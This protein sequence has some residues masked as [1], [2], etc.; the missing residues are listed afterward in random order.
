MQHSAWAISEDLPPSAAVVALAI[1][2]LSLALLIFAEVRQAERFRAGVLAT[3]L[4]AA[5]LLLAA[6]LR[7]VRVKTAGTEVG[8]RVVVLFD[9]SRRLLL[10][11]GSS[12]RRSS[13]LEAA[14]SVQ[15][16]FAASRVSVTAFAE[17]PLAEQRPGKS[18]SG[19][20]SDLLEALNELSREGGEH[21]KAVVVIS[22]GRLSRP[23][24]IAKPS[25]MAKALSG[26]GVPIHTVRV[27]DEAPKD[28]AVRQVRAAGAAVAHQP[29]SLSIEVACSGGLTCDKL[30][31]TVR[32]L[33]Y[34][35]EPA[36]LARGTV[37][38]KD[39]VGNVDLN[40]VLE[41]AGER[42]VEVAI[43]G[44]PGDTIPDNN[45]RFLSFG[46]TRERLR[47][48]HVAGRPTYDV[49]M[50]RTWLKSDE[51]VDLVA[52]FILRSNTDDPGTD[53]EAELAL[54]PFP[55][56]ELFTEHLPS[57]DAVVL[58]DIDALEYKLARH[59]PSLASYVESGGGLIMVGGPSSFSGG[60]YAGSALGRALPVE[61]S[62]ADKPFDLLEVVPSY[63]DVG[64]AAPVLRGVRAVLGETLPTF[65]GSNTVG[66]A[67]AGSLVLWSHP[68]RR[69]DG[70]P[71]PLLAL[72]EAGDGRSIALGL[73]ATYRLAW[74]EEG[75]AAAG[76]AYGALWEGLLG[77]LMRDPRYEAARIALTTPCYA[78]EPT[79]LSVTPSTRPEGNIEVQLER[80]GVVGG[81]PQS[82]SAQARGNAT[83][84][85]PLG[86][87]E[88]GGY[89][90]RVRIGTTPPARFD[91]ACERGG[92]AWAD[93][94]PDP[95]RMQAI[96]RA[97]SGKSVPI[98]DVGALPQPSATLV[99]SERHVTPLMPPWAWA[100]LSAMAVGAHWLARRRAGLS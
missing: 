36:L 46:V 2:A 32:E 42:I 33:R 1:A 70:E 41:R 17:H 35:A 22:D 6:V 90:A 92:A 21:P 75:A 64:R 76:R 82:K 89:T 61:L 86:A 93:S 63:T 60:G 16:H 49:R 57:F 55:V 13:A 20:S 34:D 3:G 7:P 19:D 11:L 24:S 37:E 62:D 67:R 43:E 99:A 83:V 44:P 50:L 40:I 54:I 71:M 25:E 68:G 28:A 58:Q 85:V 98:G 56:D 30:P 15:K 29:L 8:P 39:G 47:L 100:L 4:V 97:T 74:S 80:L 77:W 14:D 91:F 87:L 53:D 81:K 73:D 69:A 48:L 23:G 5:A 10:P 78:G 84:Q 12:T 59:L 95:E 96:A 9:D 52:F 18:P 79:N 94:R 66:A 38:V 31:L 45:R 26:L 27:T 88:P 51:S 65:V 72:G